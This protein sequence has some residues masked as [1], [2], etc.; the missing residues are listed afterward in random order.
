MSIVRRNRIGLAALG[1]LAFSALA[2]I[3]IQPSRSQAAP[4]G[5]LLTGL[6][7]STSGEKMGGVVVSAQAEGKLIIT[8]VYTDDQ[9][10]YYFPAMDAGSYNVW[11][12][13]VGYE[14]GRGQ[15]N[16]NGAVRSQNFSMKSMPDFLKQ[17]SQDRIAAALPEDTPEHR[18]M[19]D[20]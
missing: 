11:A 5:M 1:V 9:G 7:T 18:K 19:K 2:M 14:T 3:I 17:L 12:Q 4:N 10:R 8:S 20:V 16:L 6:V 15:V 13:A